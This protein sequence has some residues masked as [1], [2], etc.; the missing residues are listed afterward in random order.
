MMMSDST[1]ATTS[2]AVQ[3]EGS[4]A[5]QGL[6]RLSSGEVAFS[7]VVSRSAS[8]IPSP[9]FVQIL[10]RYT[11]PDVVSGAFL[12][13]GHCSHTNGKPTLLL[14]AHAARK[15]VLKYAMKD[16]LSKEQ[17]TLSNSVL[18]S[19]TENAIKR[20]MTVCGHPPHDYSY[21]CAEPVEQDDEGDNASE[22]LSERV[23]DD[24]RHRNYAQQRREALSPAAA[25]AAAAPP[26][27]LLA[28][29]EPGFFCEHCHRVFGKLRSAKA[30]QCPN[31]SGYQVLECAVQRCGPRTY[32]RVQPTSTDTAMAADAVREYGAAMQRWLEEPELSASDVIHSHSQVLSP[33]ESEILI[34]QLTES[35]L[36]TG[37]ASNV[38]VMMVR[39]PSS[40][41][42]SSDSSS[43]S[44]FAQTT[45]NS[46]T[47]RVINQQHPPHDGQQQQNP[48]WTKNSIGWNY[49]SY[50]ADELLL[51][52]V[53]A[54]HDMRLPVELEAAMGAVV[55]EASIQDLTTK[56][57]WNNMNKQTNK[58]THARLCR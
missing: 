42:S 23:D 21:G 47:L 35:T 14:S 4:T 48:A 2:T 40:V 17:E 54:F 50:T 49:N 13:S 28:P 25:G 3:T 5:R 11:K 37:A 18:W 58:I 36:V 8:K 10:L 27:P 39:E 57:I 55:T 20:L 56:V 6:I 1:T 29:P 32:V 26:H 44:S 19:A 45:R 41:S 9:A 34:R 43:A 31:R 12:C 24:V 7:P 30:H 51:Y 22:H 38:A 16:K 15:H 46:E 52:R 53:L 33:L